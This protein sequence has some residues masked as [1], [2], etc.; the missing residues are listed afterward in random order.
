MF[1]SYQKLVVSHPWS[2][3]VATVTFSA[4]VGDVGAQLI[5]QRK[6][7]QFKW[8]TWRTQLQGFWGATICGVPMLLW[9]Q[10]LDK[11]WPT[12]IQIPKSS[13]KFWKPVLTKQIVHQSVTCPILN[14]G[15]LTYIELANID[16][17]H[18]LYDRIRYRM[19][20]DLVN[21]MLKSLGFWGVT[22]LFNFVFVPSNMRVAYMCTMQTWWMLLL[23]YLSHE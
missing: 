20:N 15:F 12:P 19:E 23:S 21:I 14:A 2:T 10:T 11:K 9:F 17:E 3:A 18:T 13:L 6:K 7:N 8:D 5:E 16:Q 1:N 4:L 22:H